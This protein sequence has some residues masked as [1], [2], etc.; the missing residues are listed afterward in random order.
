M[1]RIVIAAHKRG[2]GKTTVA[3]NLAGALAQLG[4]RVLP[5]DTDPQGA[6]SAALGV[7]PGKPTLC[8]ILSGTA[9]RHDESIARIGLCVSWVEISRLSHRQSRQIR[10]VNTSIA[11]Y[12]DRKRSDGVGL[13]NHDQNATVAGQMAKQLGDLGLVLD[14]RLVKNLLAGACQPF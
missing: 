4:M 10:Y 8:E 2:S 11:S 14:E 13:V 12:R 7:E 6:A 5:V 1:D 3:V 9:K